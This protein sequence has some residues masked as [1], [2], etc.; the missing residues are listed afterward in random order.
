MVVLFKTEKME[1]KIDPKNQ[2]KSEKAINHRETDGKDIN[3][4][5]EDRREIHQPRDNA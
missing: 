3:N 2:R 4:Q 1:D 5:I